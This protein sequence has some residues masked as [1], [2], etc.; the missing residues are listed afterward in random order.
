MDIGAGMPNPFTTPNTGLTKLKVPKPPKM[1]KPKAPRAM[2]QSTM[3]HS[4]GVVTMPQSGTS[5][6]NPTNGTVTY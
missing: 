2:G 6:M 4:S 1:P 3:D 5:T